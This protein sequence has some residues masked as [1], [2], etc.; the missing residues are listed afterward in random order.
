MCSKTAM[1]LNPVCRLA[2]FMGNKEK[3]AMINSFVYSNFGYCPLVWHFC[4]CESSQK[5][6]KIQ[7]RCLRLELD[8]YE[9]DHGNLIKKNG[10]PTMEIKSLRTLANEIFKTIN[11]IN[12]SYMK[13]IFTSKRKAKIRP[14]DIIVRHH[15]TATY[16]DKSLTALGPKICNNLPTNI[17][18]LTS[19]TK[20]KEY[21]RT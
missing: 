19:I 21:I 1:Q 15:N 14:H 16:G 17:K 7:K 12:P 11:N 3:I 5:I 18:S 9:S 20:F 10:T 13:N 8:D 2:K 6:E 4:S